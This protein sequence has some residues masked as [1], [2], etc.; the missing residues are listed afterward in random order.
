[1]YVADALA[2][3]VLRIL[4]DEITPEDDGAETTNSIYFILPKKDEERSSAF[5]YLNSIESENGFE[6]TLDNNQ[7]AIHIEVGPF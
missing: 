6:R 4:T 7:H 3:G 5:Q 1:M 2:A